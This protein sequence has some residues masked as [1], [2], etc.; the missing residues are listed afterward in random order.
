MEVLTAPID[1]EVFEVVQGN[2]VRQ[3]GTVCHFDIDTF[4]KTILSRMVSLHLG[5]MQSA[6]YSDGLVDGGPCLELAAQLRVASAHIAN[7]RA[8]DGIAV[9]VWDIIS[10]GEKPA[11]QW[12]WPCRCVGRS[13]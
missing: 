1:I 4:E 6:R 8:L 9:H 13:P 2:V 5:S 11:S 10:V 12:R 7:S 3:L